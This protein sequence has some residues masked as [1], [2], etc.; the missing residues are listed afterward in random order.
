M[1]IGDFEIEVSSGRIS[2]GWQSVGILPDGKKV[3]SGPSSSREAAESDVKQQAEARLYPQRRYDVNRPFESM[4]KL[5]DADRA[6]VKHQA[7]Q[8]LEDSRDFLELSLD[9]NEIVRPEC[10]HCGGQESN[11]LGDGKH[12]CPNCGGVFRAN[13][14]QFPNQ[15]PAGQLPPA[16]ASFYPSDGGGGGGGGGFTSA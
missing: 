5:S 3:I 4:N 15:Y 1:K 12:K 14:N 2:G 11:D 9:G 8:L 7:D 10:P 16:K 6:I 13:I